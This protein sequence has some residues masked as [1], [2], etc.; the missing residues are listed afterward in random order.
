MLRVLGKSQGYVRTQL[1]SLV[2]RKYI[3]SYRL[4]RP[5]KAENM[6]FLTEEGKALILQHSKIFD[7]QI[8]L[9]IGQPLFVADYKH[10]RGVVSLSM[11][12]FYTL[13]ALEF[14]VVEMLSYF[15]KQG[16][17]RKSGTL[18]AMTKILLGT[19]TTSFYIPDGIFVIEKDDYKRVLLLEH[20]CDFSATRVMD[21]MKKH[22]VSLAYGQAALRFNVKI[23][24]LVLSS[25]DNEGIKK[26]VIER[27]AALKDFEAFSHLF[28]FVTLADL[29]N[30]GMAWR[31]INNQPIV[32]DK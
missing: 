24:P 32:F 13:I 28:F 12:L 7:S 9:V 14:T 11:S 16:E 31:T 21:Q 22:M 18:E 27:L 4:D 17:N 19:D 10:R 25:F 15:D 26:K 1:A 8:R 30:D 5:G 23:N 20:Y 3:K 29:Q 6:Y 2:N